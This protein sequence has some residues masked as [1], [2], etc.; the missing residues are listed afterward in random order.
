MVDMIKKIGLS[1]DCMSS[2]FCDGC[3]IL[4][5]VLRIQNRIVLMFISCRRDRRCC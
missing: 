5:G 2:F 3:I 1:Q 4:D